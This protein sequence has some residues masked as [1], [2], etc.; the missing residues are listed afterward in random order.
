MIDPSLKRIAGMHVCEDGSIAIVW[1]AHDSIVDEITLYDSCV[2]KREIPLVIAEGI[3]ARGRMI[4]IAWT[5]K[6]M[7][8][9]LL[10]RGCKMLPDPAEDSDAMSE[11]TWRDIWERMRTKRFKVVRRL[12]DWEDEARTFNREK[13]KIPKDSHPL[14]AATRI[15][16]SQIKMAKRI[17]TVKKASKPERRV[18]VI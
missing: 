16:V 9:D 1:L 18:A 12:K 6:Q 7:A 5:H 2:F 14:M 11:I 13:N 4:P 15:A 10:N 3:N 8:D 17:N